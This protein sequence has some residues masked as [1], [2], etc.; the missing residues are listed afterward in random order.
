[1]ATKKLTPEEKAK[2]A[3]QK[4]RREKQVLSGAVVQRATKIYGSLVNLYNIP[5]IKSLIDEA[6]IAEYSPE[7]FLR[8][9][10]QTEWAKARTQAQETYDV[11]RSTDPT[12]ADALVQANTAIV[13]RILTAKN[14]SASD[15]DVRRI[16]ESGTRNGWTQA[17]YDE[18]APLDV[19]TSPSGAGQAAPQQTDLRAI[20]KQYGVKVSDSVIESYTKDIVSNRRTAEQFEEEM[21]QSAI[22]LYPSIAERLQTSTFENIVSPY[23]NIY[24]EV[25][26]TGP[27][28]VDFSKPE[29]SVVFNAGDPTKPRMMNAL[30]FSTSLRK[31]PEW[32]NTQNAFRTYSQAAQALDKIFG[33][34][35]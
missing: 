27:D 16:A 33:G 29:Y 23:R 35:R 10:D 17:E 22:T 2:N 1:M 9:F 30:E 15:E 3:R 4:K 7:E 25:L 6:Y 21:R 8:R 13:R 12:Q 18:N 20:A 24:S 11:L 26:E 5:E 34:T 32:Q 28:E 31:K 19:M 14:I